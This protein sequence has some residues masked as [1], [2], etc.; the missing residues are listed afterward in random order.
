MGQVQTKSR[1]LRA[2]ISSSDAH[3][4]VRDLFLLISANFFFLST[5]AIPFAWLI[6]SE[7]LVMLVMA[8][9]LKKEGKKERKMSA[10]LRV[11]RGLMDLTSVFYLSGIFPFLYPSV[12]EKEASF[13]GNS[14]P[15]LSS[16]PIS[17]C[18]LFICFASVP[19][20]HWAM[21]WILYWAEPEIKAFFCRF[22]KTEAVCSILL[23][24]ILAGGLTLVS[25]KCSVWIAPFDPEVPVVNEPWNPEKIQMNTILGSDCR[26]FTSFQNCSWLNIFRHPFYSIALFPFLP[27]FFVLTGILWLCGF[28]VWFYSAAMAMAWLQIGWWVLGAVFLRRLIEKVTDVFFSYAIWAFYAFSFP[29]L[30]TFVPERLTLTLF[31]L[32]AFVY[33]RQMSARADKSRL[34]AFDFTL[35]SAAVGTTLTSALI[36]VFSIWQNKRSV[37]GFL[38]ETI[39]FSLMGL[40]L[41]FFLAPSTFDLSYGISEC[42]K[43]TSI[44]GTEKELAPQSN[45]HQCAQFLNFLAG[46]LFPPDVHA[47]AKGLHHAASASIKPIFLC[48]GGL[49]GILSFLGFWAFR[50]SEFA[51]AAF[52]WFLTAVFLLGIL[53]FGARLNEMVLYVSYFSWAIL[54]LCTLPAYR[55]FGPHKKLA[56]VTVL[57]LA[58]VSFGWSVSTFLSVVQHGMGHFIVP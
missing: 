24:V 58:I 4:L 53:G 43:W 7:I 17:P 41:T 40:V 51:Q 34:S 11:W 46:N 56:S 9:L 30:F 23:F 27:F 21:G 15:W 5:A 52:V 48:L 6:P 18:T 31:T 49:I 22:S 28:G 25:T 37:R 50:K 14:A 38:K 19:F 12:I 8:W 10:W 39:R 2:K 54:P 42:F 47:D 20:V 35:A 16:W 44:P 32:L 26:S 29:V 1:T 3:S 45:T 57:L 13:W 36:P 33:F 55:L